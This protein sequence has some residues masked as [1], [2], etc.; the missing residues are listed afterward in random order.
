[1]EGVEEQQRRCRGVAAGK[2]S[3]QQPR[4]RQLWTACFAACFKKF[5]IYK[6]GRKRGEAW[7]GAGTSKRTHFTY[8]GHTQFSHN[9]WGREWRGAR[10]INIYISNTKFW[11]DFCVRQQSS[12]SWAGE[13]KTG[14]WRCNS[15]TMDSSGNSQG[16][17]NVGQKYKAQ[18]FDLNWLWSSS[19]MKIL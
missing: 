14:N 19:R 16:A 17:Q 5:P 18:N 8:A 15:S 4:C 13:N 10:G 1:M 11:F 7:S 2:A 12:A 9:S 3:P 6:R